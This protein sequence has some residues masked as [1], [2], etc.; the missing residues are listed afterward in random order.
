MPCTYGTRNPPGR[1]MERYKSAFATFRE[2]TRAL[3]ERHCGRCQGKGCFTIEERSHPQVRPSATRRTW[4][5]S[6]RC[7]A[8]AFHL[9]YGL[10]NNNEGTCLLVACWMHF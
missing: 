7:K 4:A 1:L 10:S 6:F 5:C 9:K 3:F 8:K 2:G